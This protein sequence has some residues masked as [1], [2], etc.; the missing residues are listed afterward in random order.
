MNF[1]TRSDFEGL[2]LQLDLQTID[3]YPQNDRQVSALYGHRSGRTH[4][5]FALSVLDRKPLTTADKRLSTIAD[6][7][8]AVGSPGS[9]LVPALPGNPA[10]AP[11]WTAAFDTNFNGVADL[12]EPTLGLPPVSGALT[13]LFADPDCTTIA[14]Q[15]PTVVPGIVRSVP[16]PAGDIGIGLCQFDFG[17]F[18]SLVPEE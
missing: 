10:F 9:F 17:S 18:F 8:S 7:L 13:P 6:D 11:V 4:L 16:S 5:L 2:E 14:A 3:G 1:I 15:D 12:V